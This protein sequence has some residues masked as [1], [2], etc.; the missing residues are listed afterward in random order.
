MPKIMAIW[1]HKTHCKR[2][3]HQQMTLKRSFI[4]AES[5]KTN[6]LQGFCGLKIAV[7]NPKSSVYF[8]RASWGCC[9]NDISD[10]LIEYI[11]GLDHVAPEEVK[12]KNAWGC[13]GYCCWSSR[14]GLSH[15]S[16]G[17]A[18]DCVKGW[19][20]LPTYCTNGKYNSVAGPL[21]KLKFKVC[22]AIRWLLPIFYTNQL[23]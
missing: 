12:V 1:A 4:S 9:H 20:C 21:S 18:G 19:H 3:T 2:L 15:L 14:I 8:S 5:N 10:F 17:Q 7:Q 22:S 11:N 16:D 23:Y 6:F 13:V